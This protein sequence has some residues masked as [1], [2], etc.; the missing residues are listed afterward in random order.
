ML[1]ASFA[2]S[3]VP[4]LKAASSRRSGVRFDKGKLFSRPKMGSRYPH[5]FGSASVQQGHLH[6]RNWIKQI[7]QSVLQN[8]EVINLPVK[9]QHLQKDAKNPPK[10]GKKPKKI[11]T[12]KKTSGRILVISQVLQGVRYAQVSPPA[13][14][15]PVPPRSVICG[16]PYPT[17]AMSKKGFQVNI[18]GK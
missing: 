1:A 15:V 17:A 5:P 18:C 7:P 9:K 3:V 16:R 10:N 4:F 14:P 13:V 8:P 2:K 11:W 6:P 12:P